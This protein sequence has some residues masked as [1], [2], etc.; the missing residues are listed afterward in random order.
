MDK[1]AE[2]LEG[3]HETMGRL[4]HSLRSICVDLILYKA[5][6]MGEW[7]E[8]LAAQQE[9]ESVGRVLRAMS[10][11]TV[12]QAEAALGKL[13]AWNRVPASA[14][15]L[16]ELVRDL[17]TRLL[18]DLLVLKEGSTEVFLTAAMR[19]PTRA[20]RDA[21]VKLADVDRQ[22]ADRLRILLGTEP[23]EERVERGFEERGGEAVGAHGSREPHPSLAAS[24][25]TVLR[26][27]RS[28]RQEPS[29][30]ILSA[31]A[32]RH[33]RDEG[34]LDAQEGTAFGLPVDVDFGWRGECFA[35]LT[36]ERASLAEVIAASRTAHKP[37][38]G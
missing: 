36:R 8:N 28:E 22:H 31:S 32:L 12:D 35:V 11:E 17:Q 27:L 30:I 24:V 2:P 15:G 16:D 26:T 34:A 4:S 7:F 19:A 21:L 13:E 23:V 3:A 20:L 6:F 5:L 25:Q 14:D 29:R 10:R 33:A 38:F 18:Q 37:P 9:D 1:N